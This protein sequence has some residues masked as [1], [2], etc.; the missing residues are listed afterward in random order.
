MFLENNF[1][2]EMNERRLMNTLMWNIFEHSVLRIKIGTEL[3]SHPVL[4]GG[5][6]TYNEHTKS[7]SFTNFAHMLCHYRVSIF[8]LEISFFYAAQ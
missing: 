8:V 4:S 1:F 6:P 2:L 5:N 3:N 7:W